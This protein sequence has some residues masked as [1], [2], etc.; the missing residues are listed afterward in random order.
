MLRDKVK[1]DSDVNECFEEEF[2]LFE[3]YFLKRN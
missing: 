1:D 2:V 3:N